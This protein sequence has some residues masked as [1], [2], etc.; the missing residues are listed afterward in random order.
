M[1]TDAILWLPPKLELVWIYFDKY[2]LKTQK[3]YI[4]L[5]LVIK[6]KFPFTNLN[7]Q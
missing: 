6:F 4:S 3:Y 2:F 1:L 5:R 7:K